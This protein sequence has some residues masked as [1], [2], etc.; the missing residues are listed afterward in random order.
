[1]NEAYLG[2]CTYMD[3]GISGGSHCSWAVQREERLCD[4][5]RGLV[6]SLRADG[7]IHGYG[8]SDKDS[9]SHADQDAYSHA[10]QD[11]YSDSDLK[12]FQKMKVKGFFSLAL[13]ALLALLALAPF[14]QAQVAPPYIGTPGSYA[15]PCG[16]PFVKTTSI[17]IAITSATTTALI[18]GS[19]GKSIYVC[20]VNFLESGT[21]TAGIQFENSNATPCANVTAVT[22]V[23]GAAIAS[24]AI[25]VKTDSLIRTQFK[26]TGVGGLC[27]VSSG[28]AVNVSGWLIY[29]QQ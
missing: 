8:Y 10:D 14:A 7:A 21:S 22:G 12:R 15:D 3:P 11:A 25:N 23:M 13:V 16:A 24:T 19:S 4:D 9:D 17:P 20:G 5:R 26:A 6:R 29:T 28:A 1:M 18:A 27:A 2:H